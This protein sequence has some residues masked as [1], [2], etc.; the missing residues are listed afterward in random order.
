[1]DEQVNLGVNL[2]TDG[3]K[4][5]TNE[6][7]KE[8]TL[9]KEIV[10][11]FEKIEKISKTLK[12]TTVNISSL[13]D[14]KF[15]KSNIK[16]PRHV[17]TNQTEK[18]SSTFAS[19]DNKSEEYKKAF[20]DYHNLQ[21]VQLKYLE[22]QVRTQEQIT[23]THKKIADNAN[24]EAD[25]QLK[26]AQAKLLNAK[27]AEDKTSPEFLGAKK[28]WTDMVNGSKNFRA[29][30]EAHPELF[31]T[32]G[33]NAS[34]RL[35]G[36]RVLSSVG[37]KASSMGVGGRVA[38]D[39]LNVVGAMLKAPAAG[40]MTALSKA[41]TA[42]LD[43]SKAAVQAYAEIES[44]KTQLGVV[45]S[46]QTEANAMFSDIAQYA[47]KSPFGVQ[48]TSE[49]A[50]LLKQSGVYA[51]DL[52]N[53]LK[54]IGDTAGG[55]ME[56]MKRIANNYAQIVS[57]GK[58]S[59]LDMRQFAYAGIP[60]FEAVSKELN[61]S[62]QELRRLIS[63]GK[64]TSDI[65]EK[66]FKDLTGINGI[67]ENA[68]EKGAKTLKARL[69][70]LQDAKQLAMASVGEWIVKAGTET[71]NDSYANNLV[72]WAESIYQWLH[73]N[74]STV[75]IQNDVKTIANRNKRIEELQTLIAQNKDNKEVLKVLEAELKYE[76]SKR[77]L[78]VE[79]DTYAQSY[80]S[81]AGRFERALEAMG[82]FSYDNAEKRRTQLTPASR[83]NLFSKMPSIL[84]LFGVDVYGGL[85]NSLAK[86]L[87]SGDYR[88][89]NAEEQTMLKDKFDELVKAMYAL[90]KVT[91]EEIQA[92]RERDILQAQSLAYDQMNSRADSANSLM[93]SF[94]ELT[95]IYRESDE[96]KAQQEE[97]HQKK[98]QEALD[99]LKNIAKNTD[100]E[101]GEVDITNF[102]A[103]EF[104]ELN[105]KGAFEATGKLHVVNSNDWSKL[106]DVQQAENRNQLVNQYSRWSN[107]LYSFI[108][109]ISHT[110]GWYG[111]SELFSPKEWERLAKLNNTEFLAEFDKLYTK[112]MA[113]LDELI[114]RA[115]AKQ[116]K[117]NLQIYQSN[118]N[119]SLN[120][121]GTET[122]GLNATTTTT[123][124]KQIVQEFIPLWKRILAS[125]TG[126][127][128]QGMTGTLQTMENYR[129]D[130][131]IRN[132]TA[133]VLS[134]TFKS[135]G[136]DAAM[137]L[138]RT[139]GNGLKLRGDIDYTYQVDWKETKKAIHDFATQLSASTEVVSA[140]KKG[141]EDELDVYEKLMVSGFTESESQ[142]L[143]KQKFVS[144]K[145]L[146]RL[147]D[148]ARTQLVNAFGEQLITSEGK[149]IK[150][151]ALRNIFIDNEGNKIEEAEL[152]MTGK[153][154]EFIKEELPRLQNEL[155]E[156]NVTML[157]NQVLQKMEEKAIVQ[158]IISGYAQ[159]GGYNEG[160]K[161]LL[162]NEEY[163]KNMVS[164]YIKTNKTG[165]KD[166]YGDDILYA[167]GT[168]YKNRIKDLSDQDIITKANLYNTETYR[169][170]EERNRELYNREE[171]GLLS[172]DDANEMIELQN[173][174]GQITQSFD[175]L[176]DAIKGTDSEITHLLNGDLY[177]GL[178]ETNLNSQR[179][180]A[181]TNAL[182][183]LSNFQK[184]GTANPNAK[185]FGP[186]NYEGWRGNKARYLKYGFGVSRDYDMEDLYLQAALNKNVDENGVNQFGVDVSKFYK[187]DS[188]GNLTELKEEF[189]GEEGAQKMLEALTD[190]DKAMIDLNQAAKDTSETFEKMGGELLKAFSDLGKGVLD[191]PLRK[192]G[193]NL[194]TGKDAAEDMDSVFKDLSAS[195]LQ[196]SGEAM[197]KAGWDLVSRGA[198]NNNMAMIAGG[199]AL[200]GA[201]AFIGGIGSGMN[202]D[203]DKN[204]DE[205]QK[206]EKLKDDLLAL[207]RQAREDSIYYENTLRHKRAISSNDSFNVKNVHDAI[208]TPQ[209]DVV[210]TDP[211]DYL[212][213]TKTPKTL[214]GGGAPTIN[215]SVIDKSTGIVVTQQKSSYDSESN[216]IDF[217]AIIE[218][219]VQEVIASDKGDEAFAAREMRING[220][221]VI[222]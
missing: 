179:N 28:A 221:Q 62:Q 210:N 38:G 175:L 218:S 193:E 72:S 192:M 22:E 7:I 129:D 165:V 27:K 137:N 50:I 147:S 190:A 26:T 156:A 121:I 9:L 169:K 77:D 35:Q 181:V 37:D 119:A 31:A 130:M 74:V 8:N 5:F 134:S 111:Q 65:I 135:I 128:T 184:Y 116:G 136:M 124:K 54:M 182:L 15:E 52:M 105:K 208:I 49:L 25:A 123:Q 214:I 183:D 149:E 98:L 100:P 55:N 43:F 86:N 180:L 90:E 115:P 33:Q 153:L 166:E 142:D 32:G 87:S 109:N 69:Q 170:M 30:R 203:K 167:N 160:L 198:L 215:F 174:I 73:D 207:L 17:I 99:V 157:N 48:Q 163:A 75:N 47:V 89:L 127:S 29:Y 96:Y 13:S 151:D 205:T 40:W 4:T 110:N 108:E 34:W 211:R 164:E 199:L 176:Q 10:S 177:K 146:E 186:E 101:T 132:M 66:V 152:R 79:R 12:G 139:Q 220:R 212:I 200:A 56:K 2:E 78:D 84:S 143:K 80:D 23:R 140:Y 91:K 82:D 188:E 150:Y 222:A 76:L 93:T 133:G 14:A 187:K 185:Y 104:N 45:F 161:F 63:D 125:S 70:N 213:A 202:Q 219:K 171:N 94:R 141:L 83:L 20:E 197:V 81:K 51:S 216:S 196:A 173:E 131:A 155:H 194:A 106:T 118:L 21:K 46:N 60:I 217:E 154:F 158:N 107:E 19:N 126:L 16:A 42:V 88:G 97:A 6:L 145:T 102:T 162:S 58:A 92:D 159:N 53:T 85:G 61:V 67:F 201:G 206:L 103:N 71:G 44:T 209:G 68:T 144:T 120:K 168:E 11:H 59:M 24:K 122:G 3:F 41:T 172:A 138:L 95:S 64:V 57:I 18:G 112:Q 113:K 204:N 114:K 178:D 189:T 117:E 39:A 195:L 191:A 1:M 148:D 36:A